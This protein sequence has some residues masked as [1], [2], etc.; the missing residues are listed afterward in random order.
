MR[1]LGRPRHDTKLPGA[2]W[3]RPL[4]VCLATAIAS[5]NLV[6]GQTR[7]RWPGVV[8]RAEADLAAETLVIAGQHLLS[9]GALSVSLAGA[10]LSVMSATDSEIVAQLPRGLEPGAY[11][12]VLSP[13]PERFALS[14]VLT[15]GTTGPPG[16]AGAPGREGPPGEP[17]ANGINGGPGP[18]GPTGPAG[19][20]G[21]TARGAWAEGSRYVLDDVAT[22]GGQSWRCSVASC[23]RLT[24]PST[25]DEQW[26][27]LAA[28]GA[29]GRDGVNGA[30]GVDGV[31]GQQGPPGPPGPAYAFS[32]G[33]DV[34][35]GTNIGLRIGSCGSGNYMWGIDRD[36]YVLC[37][38]AVPTPEQ[39]TATAI[40]SAAATT[41]TPSRRRFCALI[42]VT[43]NVF[44]HRCS[45]ART[46]GSGIWSVTAVAADVAGASTT[47]K[48]TCF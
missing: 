17:G 2:R 40:S 38:E 21:L 34:V 1:R 29:D 44:S 14:F 43:T 45:V 26:E 28:K 20:K 33:F 27:L 9:K 10:P 25:T 16:A 22:H 23:A 4:M 6:Q 30:D 15:I 31:A 24:P 39:Y 3:L 42:D 32:G 36:G 19:P 18:A 41:Q 11:L 46:P 37:S 48:M 47:C 8:L 12:L 35:G 7:V 13:G 5:V